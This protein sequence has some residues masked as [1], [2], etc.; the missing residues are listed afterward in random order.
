MPIIK[1]RIWGSIRS[2]CTVQT[3]INSV[4]WSYW[5]DIMGRIYN[6]LLSITYWVINVILEREQ[7]NRS[8]HL[9]LVICN[10]WYVTEADTENIS[11]IWSLWWLNGLLLKYS[12][13]KNIFIQVC[14]SFWGAEFVVFSLWCIYLLGDKLSDGKALYSIFSMEWFFVIIH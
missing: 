10:N 3:L 12:I 11:M 7:M 5:Q 4:N 6:L 8:F 13:N 2:N 14:L 1:R 9:N